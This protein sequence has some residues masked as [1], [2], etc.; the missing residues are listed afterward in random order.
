MPLLV[1]GKTLQSIP[2]NFK[3][4]V[5]TCPTVKVRAYFCDLVDDHVSLLLMIFITARIV[6][7]QK[8]PGMLSNWNAKCQT[9]SN[10]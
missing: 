3:L 1:E 10:L 2:H 8:V 5:D 6:K 7:C 9:C 4:F